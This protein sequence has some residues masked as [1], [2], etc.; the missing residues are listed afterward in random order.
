[1]GRDSVEKRFVDAENFFDRHLYGGI[2]LDEL[3]ALDEYCE[4]EKNIEITDYNIVSVNREEAVSSDALESYNNKEEALNCNSTYKIS[5]EGKWKFDWVIRPSEKPRDFFATDFDSSLWKEIDVPSNAE[6]NGYGVPLYINKVSAMAIYN[7]GYGKTNMESYGAT[8]KMPEYYNPVCS[9]IRKIDIPQHWKTRE[10]YIV[11]DGAETCLYL[12]V[13]GKFAGYSTDSFT[14]KIFNITDFI[15]SGENVIACRTY[16]YSNGV[17]LENQD[18]IT[19]TGLSRKIELYSKPKTHIRDFE[20]VTDFDSDYCNAELNLYADVTS[21]GLEASPEAVLYDGNKEICRFN[22]IKNNTYGT[23]SVF[24]GKACIKNV[25]KWSAEKPKLYTLLIQLFDYEGNVLEVNRTRVGFRKVEIKGTNMLINGKKIMLKG[26]NRH[27]NCPDTGRA[28]TREQMV[29]DIQLMKMFNVNAVRTCHYPN[30]REWY[31]LCDE[32]GLYVM[33]ESN[34]ETHEW[35]KWYPTDKPDWTAPCLDRIKSSFERDKNHPCVCFWSLGNEAGKGNNFAIM[36]SWFHVNDKSRRPVHYEGD[37]ENSDMDSTMYTTPERIEQKGQVVSDKPVMLC[38]YSHAMGN[39]LGHFKEYW[40]IFEK[41]ENLHGGFI[42]DFVDQSVEWCDKHGAVMQGLCNE[43]CVKYMSYAGD[44]EHYGAEKYG[45]KSYYGNDDCDGFGENGPANGIFNADRTPKPG[46]YEMKYIH[47]NI[48]VIQ[49]DIQNG[50]FTLVNKFNFTDT[51][52][53]DGEYIIYEDG[54]VLKREIMT[55]SVKAGQKKD[56]TVDYGNIAVK[57]GA[58]YRIS[59]EFRLKKDELYAKKGHVVA[60]DQFELEHIYK[61]RIKREVAKTVDVSTTDTEIRISNDNLMI[62]FD[63]KKGDLK[64]YKWKGRDILTKSATTTLLEPDFARIFSDNDMGNRMYR[65]AKDWSTAAECRKLVSIE[66]VGNYGNYA[67]VRSEYILGNE[68]KNIIFYDL[69]G[70]GSVIVYNQF[71]PT[72]CN[73]SSEIPL[74]ANRLTL[75]AA[76]SNLQWYGRGPHENYIDRNNSAN[77][78]IY[79]DTVDNM[80]F[81]YIRPQLTG[82]RTDVRYVLVTDENRNG[83]MARALGEKLGFYALRYT[84]REINSDPIYYATATDR[85]QTTSRHYHDLKRSENVYL[86]LNYKQSGVGG[87]D[88]WGTL[89]LPQYRVDKN[90]IYVYSYILTPIDASS[91]IEALSKSKYNIEF[92]EIG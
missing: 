43:N 23:D 16:T 42:W 83:I 48:K 84:A 10:T 28:V 86:V 91:D 12:W 68:S 71:D 1:M 18:Y 59:F 61:P 57:N 51:N 30:S 92:P 78:G 40:D 74:I 50:S 4:A 6:M 60:Y 69:L 87:T 70:D 45:L 35:W 49:K 53:F 55:L 73:T 63:K 46:A 82:N 11:F 9:Y 65:R 33:A 54:Y 88:S 27:E 37:R 38:E 47:Q 5:L 22:L 58:Q 66:V 39:S 67:R 26:V 44:W 32:Y 14:Q 3:Y 80:M 31:E 15:H 34:I 56:F 2:T 62:I 85:S 17:W 8:M 90:K 72:L 36:S 20:I 21:N 29:K 24:F 77:V 7:E 89:P 13:N 76:Y 75:G 79:N 19:F 64:V 52:E 41:Y 25:E 81:D